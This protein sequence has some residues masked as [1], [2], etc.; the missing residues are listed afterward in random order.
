MIQGLLILNHESYVPQRWHLTLMVIAV[1][2]ICQAFN[3]FF[4]RQLPLVELVALVLHFVGFF[5]ILIPL[6]V[7]GSRPKSA[8]EV[9]FTFSDGGGWG[10]TGLA[11]M[12]GILSPIF[13]MLG[14]DSA[15]HMAE[16]LRNASKSLP[17]AMVATMLINGALGLVMI[18]TFCMVLG[19]A[20][21][22]LATQ[23][24]QPFI[25]VFY[26]AVQSKAG[27]TAMTCIL[28]VM[29]ACGV[30]NI[31]ATSSRQ[32]WAFARDK[33]VPFSAWF[34][35]VDARRGH[36]PI[37]ALIFSYV[38]AVL[39]SLI[40]IGSTVVSLPN[41]TPF[42]PLPGLAD[43]G[44]RQAFNI[45]TSLGVCAMMFS[46]FI[47]I[48][49]MALKHLRKEPLLPSSFSLGRMGLPLNIFSVLFLLLAFIMVSIHNNGERSELEYLLTLSRPFSPNR[50][51]HQP[52]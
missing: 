6:W 45:L 52:S 38:L 39:L 5:A 7:M 8:A 21:A 40:N 51:T 1:E 44:H 35:V 10:S 42:F 37:N 25:E 14:P 27:A 48:G 50:P 34:S 13:S 30:V 20:E 22:V 3:T 26:N 11:C 18:V 32:L 49:C 41:F 2:T 15:T 23:T 17:W 31:I 36:L 12:V 43:S 16:E 33:G 24:A 4:Y 29:V 46:Y 9:F 19:D 47:S 28:V